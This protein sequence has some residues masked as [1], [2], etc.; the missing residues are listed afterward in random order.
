MK[1]Y[2]RTKMPRDKRC[3]YHACRKKAF[4]QHC[5]YCGGWFCEEHARPIIPRH[6]FPTKKEEKFL[7]EINEWE[8]QGGHPD[9]NWVEEVNRL[10]ELKKEREREAL[11][12]VLQHEPFVEVEQAKA[13]YAPETSTETNYSGYEQGSTNDR[14]TKG[15]LDKTLKPIL[16]LALLLCVALLALQMAGVK[17]ENFIDIPTEGNKTSIALPPETHL[18]LPIGGYANH[19]F[20]F[21]NISST[22]PLKIAYLVWNGK[23]EIMKGEGNHW[24]VNKTN[25]KDGNY[26]FAVIA[27]PEDG[28]RIESGN[29]T[30]AIDTK[31]PEVFFADSTPADYEEVES[32]SFEIEVESNSS[33]IASIK[34]RLNKIEVT[35]LLI[36]DIEITGTVKEFMRF[37]KKMQWTGLEAGFYNYKVKITDFAGNSK[38]TERRTIRVE[39]LHTN[40]TTKLLAYTLRGGRGQIEF[41]IYGGVLQY[42][43]NNPISNTYYCTNGVCPTT[44]ELESRFIDDNTQKRELDSLARLIEGKTADKDDQARIA[45]SLVQNIPYDWDSLKL[46]DP[47]S[48][49]PYEVIAL[50]KGVCGEKSKLLVFLLRELGFGTALIDY[51]AERHQAVGISCPSTYSLLNSGYCFVEAT[52]PNIV[53]DDQGNY[54]EV[55]KLTSV[56]EITKMSD[57]LSFTSVSEEYQDNQKLKQLFTQLD[58]YKTTSVLPY[59]LWVQWKLIYDQYKSLS[60]KYGL[61]TTAS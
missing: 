28:K 43:Q 53:T 13:A 41:K 2:K 42:L 8:I 37:E 54:V 50:E 24:W 3:Q 20:F 17:S 56:P 16:W 40:P 35:P 31:S 4:L 57:G 12:A 29:K 48:K 61:K 1:V 5:G 22:T 21:T 14:K 25:L 55:G 23:K 19:N 59:E 7:R 32:D 44:F 38:S 52:A 58:A 27:Y 45:I 6:P 60:E 26:T 39:P 33:D 34:Y 10:H 11:N 51:K 18:E 47:H 36:E 15:I 49:Y 9:G 30:L 46:S